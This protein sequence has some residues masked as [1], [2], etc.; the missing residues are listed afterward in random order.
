MALRSSAPI[1]SSTATRVSTGPETVCAPTA[2]AQ[3]FAKRGLVV[4]GG[5]GG[6]DEALDDLDE[7]VG[8]VVEREMPGALEDL[9]LGARHRGV[10]HV[11]VADRDDDIVGAP[12]DLHRNGLRQITSVQ[13]G[14]ALAAPVHHRAQASG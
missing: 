5:L 12:D 8:V 11:G 3:Q 9:E 14:D 1:A 13:H 2:G 10:G 6:V 7:A 4:V